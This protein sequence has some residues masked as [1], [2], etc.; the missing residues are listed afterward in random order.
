[1]KMDL[2]LRVLRWLNILFGGAVILIGLGAFFFTGAVAPL[3]LALG[4]IVV[5]PL[6]DWLM[7]HLRLPGVDP[8]QTQK[9]IDQGTSL[10]FVLLLLA[11]LLLSL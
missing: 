3:L 5:G 2:L 4:L 10:V 1:M 6:E 8:V 11:A 9:L 7:N